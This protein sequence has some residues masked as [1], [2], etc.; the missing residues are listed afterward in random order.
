MAVDSLHEKV[1]LPVST[2]E[3]ERRWAA[4]RDRM[5][6]HR[7]DFVVAQ[8]GNDYL[9]GYVKWLTDEPA[10]HSYPISVILPLSDEMTTVC[11]GSSDPALAA[12]PEWALR[13]VRKRISTPVMQSLNYAA[14]QDA[15]LVAAELKRF[16]NARICLVN[17][18]AM[19]AGFSRTLRQTLTS[20]EF[21]DI[22][23][24]IDE[25]KAIKSEEEI[26]R[27]RENALMHDEAMKACFDAIA[28]GVRE[29]EIAAAG[30]NRCMML[31]SEQHIVFVA[32]AA[33]GT[34]LPFNMPHAMNRR[35]RKGDQVGILIEANDPSGF[36][37]HLSRI[38]C[39][40]AI[41]DE[42]QHHH[43]IALEAQ[44]LSLGLIR[45][46]ADPVEILRRNNEFL[47]SHGLPGETRVYAHGQG[48]DMVERPS[49]QPGETMRIAANMNIAV[50]P[51]ANGKRASALLTDNY[52][53]TETGV[54]E[55]LH[56][57]PKKL[58]SL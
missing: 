3:L 53:V 8:N 20:A 4:V 28:P 49:F 16:T 57:T 1:L 21:V 40:G 33:P 47:E 37:T 25:I 23:D 13:G 18:A 31:G 27:I 51:A 39:L 48:Y 24:E 6:E 44:N 38:A 10:M 2:A 14:C 12:P 5:T 58:F 17:E 22:T 30:R 32:S 52:I 7:I 26:E 36:Y 29:F 46:G 19:S 55:C 41:P 15:E 42:L 35:V 56:R 34:P 11:H 54:S 43:E 9:G 50:H 45:P